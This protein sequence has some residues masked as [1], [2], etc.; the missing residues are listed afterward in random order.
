MKVLKDAPPPV[1]RLRI[2]ALVRR[3]KMAHEPW[4]CVACGRP[5]VLSSCLS[6]HTYVLC[7]APCPRHRRR[8]GGGLG[9]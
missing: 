4:R 8:L 3:G 7:E 5:V 2:G 9:E 6:Y 1:L